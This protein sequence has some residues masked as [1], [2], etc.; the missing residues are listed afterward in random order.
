MNWR[1]TK[2]IVIA[3]VDNKSIQ[4]AYSSCCITTYCLLIYIKEHCTGA[5]CIVGLP[6]VQIKCYQSKLD[7]LHLHSVQKCMEVYMNTV[8]SDAAATIG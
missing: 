2:Y 8:H 1:C 4:L 6:A 3:R 5:N 7:K